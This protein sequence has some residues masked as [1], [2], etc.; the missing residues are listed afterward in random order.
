M[1]SIRRA[2]FAG[3]AHELDFMKAQLARVPLLQESLAPGIGRGTA[4][5][6]KALAR[7][8]R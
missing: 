4:L 3:I 2:D 5:L 1:I 8:S 7:G 6:T